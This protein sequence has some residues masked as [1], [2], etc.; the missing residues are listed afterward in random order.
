MTPDTPVRRSRTE[1]EPG[2][3]TAWWYRAVHVLAFGLVGGYPLTLL[4]GV[5][6]TP[7]PAWQTIW[8]NSAAVATVLLCWARGYYTRQRTA[9]ALV[10][11]ALLAQAVGD[12]L[13]QV[14]TRTEQ[15]PPSLS[16]AD[17][18]WLAYYPL[19]VA[20]LVSIVR[21]S[22]H[23]VSPVR[24]LDGLLVG[25]GTATMVIVGVF[26]AVVGYVSGDRLT[27]FTELI[28]PVLDVVVLA[29]T[30]AAASVFSWRPPASV[31]WL[32]ASAAVFAIFDGTYVLQSARGSHVPGD[33][34]DVFGL[35]AGPFAGLLA[36]LAPGRAGRASAA[37]YPRWMPFIAPF[38][39]TAA[40][41]VVL[42][43]DTV[44]PVP[45]AGLFLAAATV[46]ASLARLAAAVSDALRAG[47]HEFLALT[48]DLTGLPNRRSLYEQAKRLFP[49]G[50][51]PAG[52]S[53]ALLLLD[54]DHFKDVND[55]LGHAAGDE[56][57]RTMA[58]RMTGRLRREDV[59]A[60]LGG[61]EFAVLLPDCD[62]AAATA[63][64]AGL[65]AVLD[66]PVVLDE[67]RVQ[68]GGSIGIALSPD[69]GTDIATLLRLADIA[70]YR[71][72]VDATGCEI[73]DPSPE[74]R[75]RDSREST[76]A[77]MQLL[78]QLRTAIARQ[79]LAV[80]Y[81][82]Q[83]SLA[84][85]EIVGVEALVRWLHLQ[86][87]M[88]TPN[89]FLPLVRQHRLMRGLTEVVLARAL[90]DALDWRCRGHRIPVAVN[91]FPA[92]PGDGDGDRDLPDM[93]IAALESRGLPPAALQVEITEQFM[94]GDP[95]RAG[96][97]LDRLHEY[98]V[99]IAVDDFGTG[100]SALSHL[101]NLAIDQ[102]KLDRSFIE[103]ITHDSRAA[104]IT[105]SVIELAHTIGMTAI[106]EGVEDAGTAA[107]LAQFGC[108]HAQGYFYHRPMA[109]DEFIALLDSSA[110]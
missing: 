107:L 60:R 91:L 46:L 48:D 32:C 75:S 19:F 25:L 96:A 39:G 56:L 33:W 38:Y 35:L 6:G 21:S 100:Y 18:G 54:L 51:E 16:I 105:R 53:A 10:G 87:G 57:L 1:P 36:A 34:L 89:R 37:D 28:Y 72:K 50:A 59:L 43:V 79:E 24:A 103:P 104:A 98:G 29:A 70:M 7:F 86:R 82:P 90:D 23:V 49:A 88:L 84:T 78:E 81:Q 42:L 27:E 76:R 8:L 61:D 14:I 55:S 5:P 67:V 64:A 3:G 101:Y 97:V 108:D 30:L 26:P 2:A 15:P 9:W 83:V 109:A 85:R 77:D 12:Q 4:T 94:L 22:G 58:A 11:L 20:A 65:R 44:R 69:H 66:E 63:A 73:Y 95:E 17:V 68:V 40:A 52:R 62:A 110:G 92:A 47:E 71:A 80:F 13:W 106:A 45:P 31:W 41:V 102:V 74:L 93:V 99:G